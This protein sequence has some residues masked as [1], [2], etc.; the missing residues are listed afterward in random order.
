MKLFKKTRKIFKKSL[1]RG[2]LVLSLAVGSGQASEATKFHTLEINKV[3][4]EMKVSAKKVDIMELDKQLRLLKEALNE[5]NEPNKLESDATHSLAIFVE[6]IL[7]FTNEISYFESKLQEDPESII[8]SSN[9]LFDIA[10][11]VMASLSH[12]ERD[13]LRLEKHENLT[14]EINA[15]NKTMSKNLLEA[16]ELIQKKVDE[17]TLSELEKF[18]QSIDK[19]TIKSADSFHYIFPLSI[20]NFTTVLT[21]INKYLPEEKSRVKKATKKWK[22]HI[23]KKINESIEF[24]QPS[25]DRIEKESD[26][27]EFTLRLLKTKKEQIKELKDLKALL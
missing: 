5:E 21:K 16:L 8:R 7:K 10:E 3:L 6:R 13:I 14:K 26:K 11:E 20:S 27:S 25:I 23:S 18:A 2:V 22:K 1:L 4:T 24:I 19:K 12:F 9:K 15:L 17:K